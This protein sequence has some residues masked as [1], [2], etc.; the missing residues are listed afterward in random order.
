MEIYILIPEWE[1][2]TVLA[3]SNT[4]TPPQTIDY[5]GC[6]HQQ[7]TLGYGMWHHCLTD[8]GYDSDLE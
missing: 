1:C 2:P 7:R 4:P 5:Q 6:T 8:P 3:E